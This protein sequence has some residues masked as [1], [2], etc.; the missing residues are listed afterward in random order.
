MGF[1]SL[2]G[3]NKI[4]LTRKISDFF[5]IVGGKEGNIDN[6]KINSWEELENRAESLIFPQE[7]QNYHIG[8]AILSCHVGCLHTRVSYGN[9]VNS[10]I[11]LQKRY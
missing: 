3:T 6:H 8:P 2:F 9:F 1:V 10:F 7:I 11:T 5:K 4:F